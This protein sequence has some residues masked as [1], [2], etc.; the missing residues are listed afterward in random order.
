MPN[1]V[2]HGRE[3][4]PFLPASEISQA[5]QK[6]ADQIN[7]DYK[8]R[9]PVFIGVLNGAFMFAS[10]LFKLLHV[11]CY[12]S[13]VK[14]SSYV[15]TQSTGQVKQLMGLTESL[16]GRHVIVL[17]DIIDTGKTVVELKALLKE[18]QPGSVAIATM[19]DKPSCRQHEIKADYHGIS[20]PDEFV[21]GYGL[22]FDGLGRNYP[23]LYRT[24]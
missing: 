4:E 16:K 1:I 21:V 9:E 7:H 14:L 22:D 2:L 23:D 15:G 5:I 13:F 19:F 8:D 11:P 3:F 10:D 6:V 12:I 24:V 17:E 18:L 20:L